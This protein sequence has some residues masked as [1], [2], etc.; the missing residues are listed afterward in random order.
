MTWT[1]RWRQYDWTQTVWVMCVFLSG[2]ICREGWDAYITVLQVGCG[3][4][5]CPV[6]EFN[7]STCV[8]ASGHKAASKPSCPPPFT[9]EVTGTDWPAAVCAEGVSD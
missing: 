8:R 7:K 2:C 3:C 9:P 5:R 1:A 4:G 6:L